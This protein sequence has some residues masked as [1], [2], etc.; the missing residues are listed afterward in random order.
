MRIRGAKTEL[1]EA[2]LETEGMVESTA[3]LREEIMAL[4]GVD[5]MLNNN[6]FK[7]TYQIMEE[8]ADKWQDLSDIQQATVTELI[9]GKRQGN[10]V[11]SLMNNFDIAQNALETSLNSSGSAMA[12]HAKWQQSLEAQ[13]LKLKAAWQSLSQSFMDSNFLKGAMDAIIGLVDA[14]NWLIDTFGTLPTL[15]GAFAAFESIQGVG[16]FNTIKDEATGAATGITSAFSKIKVAIDNV[17]NDSTISFD[18]GF[19]QSLADD[20]TAL[21]GY[22]SALNSGMTAQEAFN[23]TMQSA[24]PA[25]QQYA[26]TVQITGESVQKFADQQKMSELSMKAQDKSWA[27]CSTLINT[28]NKSMQTCGLTQEQFLQ[29]IQASNPALHK[30]LSGLGNAN[31]TFKGYIASLVGAKVATFALEAATLALNAAITMGISAL[32]SF[33]IK[34]FDEMYES[35]DELSERIDEVISKFNSQQKELVKNKSSFVSDAERYAELSKGI[36]ALGR[37]VSLTTEEYSEYQSVVNSVAEQIPSLI[38]GYDSQGNAILNVKGNVEELITAY[39]KLIEAQ[40]REVLVSS[41]DIAEEFNNF[42][43]K[44][45]SNTDGWSGVKIS[46]SAAKEWTE[47]LNKGNDEIDDTI[48]ELWKS[49]KDNLSF[50]DKSK[51]AESQFGLEVD[52]FLALAKKLEEAGIERK[53]EWWNEESTEEYVA[54]AFKENKNVVNRVLDN[55]YAEL[56][57]GIDG[58][59]SVA[60]AALSNAFDIRTSDYYGMNDTLKNVARQMVNGFDYEFFAGLE[61][62]G[63]GVEEYVNNMLDQL[64]S[65]GDR[66]TEKIETAFDLQT[67][68]NGGEISYGEYVKGLEDTGKIINGLRIDKELKTQLKLSIGLNESGIVDEYQKL[69]NKLSDHV[70]YDFDSHIT[71]SVAKEFLNS[72][73]AEELSVAIPIITEMS[74]N[75][76]EESIQDIRAAINREMAVQGLTFDLNFEIEAASIDAFNTALAESVTASGLSSDSISALKGRY[77]ELENQGYDLSAMFEETS[78]GIHLNRKAVGELERAYAKQKQ[79]DITE[80]LQSLQKEYDL[81]TNDINNCNDASERAAL[82]VQRNAIAQQINDAATL[83]AQYKGLT[84]AYNDWLAAE[85]AGQERD[86]YENIIE[87]FENVDDEISRGWVDDGTIEFLELLTGKDLSTSSIDDLKA[88]YK[89]L[90]EEIGDSGYSIRDFFT[91]NEDGDSTN[92][93]VYNF[94]E[95][96]ESFDK[97]KSAIQRDSETGEITGFNFKVVGGDEAIAE[98]LGISE[99]LVQIM[100]RAADDAGFVVTLDGTYTQLADLKAEAESAN[101][102]LKKLHTTS[103]GKFGTDYTFDFAVSN[104]EDATTELDKALEV[105]NQYKK[106]GVID[107]EME[108]ADEALKV[109]E[110]LQIVKNKLEEPV[111][112]SIETSKLQEDLQEPVELLQEYERL[113]QERDLLNLSGEDTERLNEIDTELTNIATEL[114][115]LPEDTKVKLG[116]DDLNVDQ[117][118]EELENGTIEIPTELT[119][120]ANMDKSLEDLVTLGL[121]EQGLI[122]EKEARI[123]IGLEVDEVDTSAIEEA[124][125]EAEISEEQKVKII[126]IAEV[127]G[128]ENVEDLAEKLDGLTDEQIQV[129]AEVLGKV[130]VEKLKLAVN[131][132]DDKT[133]EAI[134]KALGE[135]DVESLK[136]TIKGLDDKTVKAIANAFGYDDVEDLYAAIDKLDSKTVQAIANALGITDVESLKTAIDRLTDKNVDAVANVSGESEV[137]SLRDSI[138]GLTGKTVDVIVNFIKSGWETVSGWFGGGDGDSGGSGVNGTA[139]VNGTAFSR[140]TSQSGRAFKQ[141]DWSTKKSETALVGELGREIVVTPNNRWHTVGDNGAEFTHIPRGSI[142]FNH[143]QTEELLAN[144]K[145]TSGGGRGRAFASGTAYAMHYKSDSGSTG[146]GGIGKVTESITKKVEDTVKNAV[147]AVKKSGSTGSGSGTGKSSGNSNK[148]NGSGGGGSGGSGGGSSKEEKEFEETI[149][150]IE[151]AIDRIERAL[152]KLDLKANS[153]YKT[154]SERNTALAD[155]IDKVGDEIDLQQ[156]AYDRYIKQANSVGLSESYA[157]NVRD[158]TIDI[159]TIT[160]EDLKKKID[161]YKQWYDKALDCEKAIENL[162]ET[163]AELYAQRF[164]HIQAQYDAVL[165]GYE[166]TEA[167]LNEYISQAEERGHIVSKKYYQALIDNEKSNIAELKKEQ[168]ELITARDEA[169]A[170][171]KIA[172][173]SEEWYNMCSEIDSVTQAIEESTTALLEFDNAMREIDWSIFDLIQERISGVTEEADFLIELMSNKELFDDNG[174]LTSQGLATMALHGQNYNTHMYAAD[175]LG[176][177]VAKLNKQI[178]KDPYDQEL[179]N[180]RNELLELQR[181][182]IL[183]AE[184]E[185]NAIRDMVEEGIGLELDAL[186]ELIDKKNEAL[187]SERDLYEY[188]K[189]VKE[190]TKEIASLEKQM[191]AYSG[192]D[193]EE[194]KQKIQQIKVDLEAA[195]QDLQ[196]TEYDKFV[197]DTSSMFDTLYNE[198]EL[199]LNTRLDNIDY[200]LESVIDSI[201]AA[202]GADSTIASALSS[203]GAIAIAV[204]NNATSI[205]DTLTSETNKVGVTL[206]NAMN[207]IWSTGDGNAKSVLTMYGEDFRTKST[208]IITTLNGIK[209]SVNSMVASLNKEA[210]TKTA[211]NKTTTSA[212]KNSTTTS[213]AK[214]T[215]TTKKVT[216]SG[217]GKPKIGDRV[218][219]VSGQYYYDSQGKKPLGSHNK[220]EYVYITNINTRDWA[221]HGYHIS[222]GNKLGKGD[223]GWLK[224]NQLSGYASGK[225]NF[226]DDEIAWT[227]EDGQEYIVRPSDGA[228]LTP[229]ARKG[230]VLNAQA[231]ENLWNMT[232][233]PAEFIKDNLG[234][235]S[236]SVPN[237]S[238]VQSN[239][240]QYLDKVIFNMP[241]VKNYDEFL[242]QMRKDRNFENLVLSITVDQIAGK[243]SLGKGKSIR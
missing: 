77:A 171:G 91:V 235:G 95:T 47:L 126:A 240:T 153:V 163:E 157:K 92:A 50:R 16:F 21:L 216:S 90:K 138:S 195:R 187:E 70:N 51:D 65:I 111:Y 200:L 149:D 150:W 75:D 209:S 8:L 175:E 236:A 38:S 140:G 189:K 9:A 160:D 32:V 215:T 183:A 2:G 213:T 182:S 136:N 67:Q 39:E 43:E 72:L 42:A 99:E 202:A 186:Q 28:Y 243:S 88:A 34:A 108:G 154:W 29:S 69:S 234:L 173:N 218:K 207:S 27:N 224:L 18:T 87:G 237:N 196:E 109:A 40:N 156:K 12:E 124:L 145:V 162:K 54:R 89:G 238:T 135:G 131:D 46:H 22:R 222:T 83:A 228:I 225:K 166:H 206:S 204:S 201:N 122:T 30:Y 115:N 185:K 117:I 100:V 141:G 107:L 132:L 168:S 146:S 165:Q 194:A 4:S 93:G 63:I 3:K 11:S 219:Y 191:A 133:I 125:E 121:L 233:S 60:E 56:E 179:I 102:A 232:N 41:G 178:A 31:G 142:V 13:I 223:L 180:R 158:G 116:I 101:D 193:S 118:K 96:I 106:N 37:N 119:I 176:A 227:Q 217:D 152:D 239:Y 231:S 174:K 197:D 123:R 105:L 57:S 110:T 1:E 98:A 188:Q 151:T 208:T 177:E 199:I 241:N 86:M 66:N 49:T 147:N 170:S 184:D 73:S 211:A 229:I 94:L 61:E 172:K 76:V 113:T 36:D 52:D 205:K 212:K 181:E 84:S 242:A 55:F 210:T 159:E 221:T 68:F 192:D 169:V 44:A 164:E 14:V 26:R 58:Q 64:N 15:I 17:K 127:L 167:M 129:L 161:D 104:I 134:A 155:Q 144:G 139:N 230:S 78:N 226:L 81:L 20:E 220:G 45:N 23:A 190:Q 214:K 85:E 48:D 6:E 198:Y 203:E 19:T 80:D 62:D 143:K 114:N 74:D 25:A 35:A 130:D 33:A 112:M 59:K 103:N 10:I 128:V 24:S 7:S 71:G 97:L 53:G 137:N 79:T 148:S 120:E 5:I 82:Y